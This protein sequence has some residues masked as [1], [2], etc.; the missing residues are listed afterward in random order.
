M[1]CG[2]AEGSLVDVRAFEQTEIFDRSKVFFE[3]L[4]L[5]FI[6]VLNII[7]V[8]LNYVFK[9]ILKLQYT[10][11]NLYTIFNYMCFVY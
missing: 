10:L 4:L 9:L 3:R 1:H 8:L 6:F 11:S 2:V 5:I 7:F